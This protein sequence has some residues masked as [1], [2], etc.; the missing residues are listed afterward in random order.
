M[1][2]AAVAACLLLLSAGVALAQQV[3]V[4][5]PPGPLYVGFPV[6]IRIVATDFEEQPAPEVSVSTP[7][8]GR[9]E[10]VGVQPS[11]NQSIAI[12]NGRITRTVD[13]RFVYHYRYVPAAPGVVELGPF[14]V[15]QGATKRAAHAVRLRVAELALSDRLEVRV[16]LPASPIFVGQRVPIAVEF[17]HRSW[18]HPGTYRLLEDIGLQVVAVD[19]PRLDQLFPSRPVTTDPAGMRRATGR[20][21]GN[22]GVCGPHRV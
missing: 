13:V 16:E 7:A 5:V 9:L 8:R 2:A 14:T 21:P 1:R 20:G 12:V 11:T 19:E 18:D 15:V 6:E 3:K 22:R 4:D 17:R 10:F